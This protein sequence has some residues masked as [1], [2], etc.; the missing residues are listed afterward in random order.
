MVALPAAGAG[1]PQAG[2][3][4]DTADSLEPRAECLTGR[5]LLGFLS[6]YCSHLCPYYV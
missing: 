4:A 6:L 1:S 2:K 3:T 5:L